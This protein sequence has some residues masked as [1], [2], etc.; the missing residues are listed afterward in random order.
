MWAIRH[1]GNQVSGGLIRKRYYVPFHLGLT[2]NNVVYEMPGFGFRHPHA[3]LRAQGVNEY[4]QASP[5][6]LRKTVAA[7]HWSTCCYPDLPARAAQAAEE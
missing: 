2:A 6:V 5:L 1:A 7:W 3:W 4:C